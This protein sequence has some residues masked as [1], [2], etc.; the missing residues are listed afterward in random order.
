VVSQANL[1]KR[2]VAPIGGTALRLPKSSA[3]LA[4]D[5][6]KRSTAGLTGQQG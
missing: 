3:K 4:A 1:R 2:R 5:L 6:K